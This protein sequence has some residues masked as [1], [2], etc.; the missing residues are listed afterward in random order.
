MSSY[1]IRRASAEKISYII[2]PRTV[3]EM[4]GKA[5]GGALSL[6]TDQEHRDSYMKYIKKGIIRDD[7]FWQ[8]G[9]NAL[10][11]VLVL[12]LFSE[13]HDPILQK[14]GFKAEE[15][16]E[17][18][19]PALEQFHNI[20]KSLDNK[21]FELLTKAQGEQASQEE[22]A[23]A[24]LN[25]DILQR[26]NAKPVS[27]G[28]Q[29]EEETVAKIIDEAQADKNIVAKMSNE[30]E[31]VAKMTEEEEKSAEEVQS[32]SEV[33]SEEELGMMAEVA[34]REAAFLAVVMKETPKTLTPFWNSLLKWDWKD[35]LVNQLEPMVSADFFKSLQKDK[36]IGCMLHKIKGV[37]L[38]YLEDSST[39][40]NVALLSARVMVMDREDQDAAEA[41]F[42]TLSDDELNTREE[43][44]SRLPVAA[45]IE[46][47]YDIQHSVAVSAKVPGGEDD[48]NSGEFTERLV[49]VGILEG[50]LHG[51]K[52]GE[53]RWKLSNVREPWEIP[54][55]DADFDFRPS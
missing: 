47:L 54:P 43:D 34:E 35:S 10:G 12:G 19:K 51:G 25:S 17:G 7:V 5:L 29:V 39:V 16:L 18:V 23:V 9:S 33:F 4:C 40:E 55:V 1:M 36:T 45:Q 37:D 46:V 31:T 11:P 14:Y 20:E 15:F 24:K 26:D 3:M 50:F 30:K 42:D 27:D 8:N 6:V 21:M 53:L 13:L 38:T 44:E 48:G 41:D 52:D 32:D 49:R 2:P 28:E 22:E